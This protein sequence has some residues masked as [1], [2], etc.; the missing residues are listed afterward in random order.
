MEKPWF[1]ILSRKWRY[2]RVIPVSWQ[3]WL[4]TA[5]LIGLCVGIAF[6]VQPMMP[7]L[8]E[9]VGDVAAIIVQMIAILLP[10]VPYILI[11]HRT[12]VKVKM[13]EDAG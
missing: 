3:G 7:D 11:A 13:V 9:N 6:L 2:Y 10:L 1:N 8:R 12:G 4:I 5:L